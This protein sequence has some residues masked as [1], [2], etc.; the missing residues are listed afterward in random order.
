MAYATISDLTLTG[1]PPK[2][3]VNVTDASK[4][5]ALDRG[6]GILNGY[7]RSQFTLPLIAPYPDDIVQANVDIA[8]WFIMRTRGFNPSDPQDATI[9]LAYD[10]AIEWAKGVARRQICPNAT[11]SASPSGRTPSPQAYPMRSQY[12]LP[13]D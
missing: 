10:D 6:F 5:A 4:Q 3:L 11:D 13:C 9:R 8:Q 12:D 1:L 7:F 2:A